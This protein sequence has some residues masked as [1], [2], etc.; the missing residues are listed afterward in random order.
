MNVRTDHEINI[1][2]VN[3]L[4]NFISECVF[5]RTDKITF[6]AKLIGLKISKSVWTGHKSV[7]RIPAYVSTFSKTGFK[8][9]RRTDKVHTL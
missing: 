2:T 3:V 7:L 6:D 4:T 1:T 8:I 9:S 5:Y